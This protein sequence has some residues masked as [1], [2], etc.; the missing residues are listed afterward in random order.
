MA[1]YNCTGAKSQSSSLPLH[2]SFRR[3]CSQAFYYTKFMMAPKKENLFN[4]LPPLPSPGCC[5]L[6]RGEGGTLPVPAVRYVLLISYS[7]TEA[8]TWLARFHIEFRCF[9]LATACMC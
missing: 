8:Q 4:R 9:L 2:S 6:G 7:F 5:W 1:K 3:Q